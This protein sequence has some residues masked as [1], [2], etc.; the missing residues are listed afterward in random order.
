MDSFFYCLGQGL[1]NI[2]RNSLFSIASIATMTTCL[3]LFGIMYF[4]LVNV[5]HVLENAEANV[6]ITTFFKEGITDSEIEA[7]KAD[8][9]AIDGVQSVEFV[10]ADSAWED[11]K[12]NY[13]K[14]DTGIASFNGENPLENS[15][16]FTILFDSVDDES[17]IV[18][19]LESRE[20]KEKGIRKVNDTESLVNTL[21]K[22]NKALS[23]GSVAIICLLL[24]I[25]TFLISTTITTGVTVRRKEIS[26]MHLIGATDIFIRGPFLVEGVLIGLLGSTVPLSLLYALYYKIVGMIV[27]HFGSVLSNISLVNVKEIFVV[28]VP[29]MLV[30]G[31]GI[32]FFGSYVTLN[33]QLAKIRQ[34]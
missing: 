27:T 17:A 2:K 20:Y 12:A 8:I 13:L 10:S 26:I 25:A 9:E 7:L 29:L 30:I 16:S 14:D 22:V 31:V 6:G 5:E 34:M 32:G 24:F 4:V 33:K 18:D 21:Q 11:Y 15:A 1:K 23:V 19:K 28:L 3:F